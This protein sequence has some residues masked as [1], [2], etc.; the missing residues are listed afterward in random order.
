MVRHLTSVSS[1]NGCTGPSMFQAKEM[2]YARLINFSLHHNHGL[3][4]LRKP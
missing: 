3:L 4:S 1:A 2:Q